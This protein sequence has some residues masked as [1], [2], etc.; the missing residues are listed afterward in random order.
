MAKKKKVE[1]K[2]E[3]P[4]K[5]VEHKVE[6]KKVLKKY[7]SEDLNNLKGSEYELINI[8]DVD[9]TYIAYP[10]KGEGINATA[11]LKYIEF[12]Y[13]ISDIMEQAE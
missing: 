5:V 9:K 10:I 2:V 1:E 11:D 8:N 4:K 3:E 13:K 7:Y 6:K 12:A